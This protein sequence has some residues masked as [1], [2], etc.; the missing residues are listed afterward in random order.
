[1]EP[2]K[3]PVPTVTKS[4]D[5]LSLPD[6]LREVMNGKKISKL[7]WK[8]NDIYCGLVDN[9]LMIFRGD[10]DSKW[11][12]WSINDGDLFGSDWFVMPEQAHD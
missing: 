12:S 6:A 8:T 4:P 11:H 2:N 7:E 9:F 5:L 3:S 10:Q 1:M